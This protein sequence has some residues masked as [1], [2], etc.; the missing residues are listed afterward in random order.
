MFELLILQRFIHISTAYACLVYFHQVGKI[1]TAQ[2]LA[3]ARQ[4]PENVSDLSLNL[5]IVTCYNRKACVAN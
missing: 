4:Y 5:G 2:S 1:I 3:F